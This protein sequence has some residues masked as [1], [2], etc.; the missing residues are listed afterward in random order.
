MRP[1]QPE[2][3]SP[4]TNMDELDRGWSWVVLA[5]S[6]GYFMIFGMLLYGVGIVHVTLLEEYDK[7][8]SATAWAGSLYASL[9]SLG[10]N[11]I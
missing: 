10:G 4:L 7:P 1:A 3:T 5:A 2:V 11:L 9:V 6:F 8:S